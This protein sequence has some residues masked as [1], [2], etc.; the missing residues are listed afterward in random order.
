MRR[1]KKKAIAENGRQRMKQQRN[2]TGKAVDEER[3]ASEEKVVLSLCKGGH[4][5]GDQEEIE[6]QIYQDTVDKQCHPS[7]NM[8]DLL[9]FL[10]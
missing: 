1:R 4:A 10:L 5:T 2:P 9:N 3:V 7:F 6:G 8:H